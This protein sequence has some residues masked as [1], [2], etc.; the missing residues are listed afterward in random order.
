MNLQDIY[1]QENN[2]FCQLTATTT[3]INYIDLESHRTNQSISLICLWLFK[4]WLLQCFVGLI[5]FHQSQSC[6]SLAEN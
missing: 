2:D 3:P 6:Q 1:I 4:S 5:I